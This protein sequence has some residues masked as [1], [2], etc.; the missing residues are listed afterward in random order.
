V[1]NEKPPITVEFVCQDGVCGIRRG[2]YIVDTEDSPPANG[3]GPAPAS[4]NP[5]APTPEEVAKFSKPPAERKS[6]LAVDKPIEPIE[7]DDLI[8]WCKEKF[9]PAFK[10]LD[11][12]FPLTVSPI[13]LINDPK[14]PPIKGVKVVYGHQGPHRKANELQAFIR[15]DVIEEKFWCEDGEPSQERF[16]KAEESLKA[17]IKNAVR[18]VPTEI[19][20]VVHRPTGP[21]SVQ[22]CGVCGNRK[23]CGCGT[24]L[25]ASNMLAEPV[26]GSEAPILSVA[27]YIRQK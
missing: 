21:S 16:E 2:P 6:R 1:S 7:Q 3:D 24:E 13:S 17:Q 9:A 8:A 27:D 15:L 25:K 14:L 4:S 11:E 5:V 18:G 10:I 20:K 19:H 23:P 22:V 26:K 12:E